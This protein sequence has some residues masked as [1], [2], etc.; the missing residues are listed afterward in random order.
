V[1]CSADAKIRV[2]HF[3]SGKTG[4]SGALAIIMSWRGKGGEGY[5]EEGVGAGGF[6]VS[7]PSFP[8]PFLPMIKTTSLSPL[9]LS[10]AP[11]LE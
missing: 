2:F 11:F 9:P 4:G 10:L 3:R 1:V 5:L 8:Y 7:R 6:T